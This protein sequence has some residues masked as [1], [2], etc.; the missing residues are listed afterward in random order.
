MVLPDNQTYQDLPLGTEIRFWRK[1]RSTLCTHNCPLWAPEVGL[2]PMRSIGIDVLH[3]YYLGPLHTWTKKMLWK[4]LEANVWEATGASA[5][6]IHL[7][8]LD[9]LKAELVEWYKS[10]GGRG[11]TE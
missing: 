4:L 11:S 2:T 5:E 8:A 6:E 3:T 1:V 9:H 7:N 10:P